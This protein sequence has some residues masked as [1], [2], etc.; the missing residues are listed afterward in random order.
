MSKRLI[1]IDDEGDG[2]QDE[3]LIA[4]FFDLFGSVTPDLPLVSQ[5]LGLYPIYQQLKLA[6]MANLAQDLFIGRRSGVGTGIPQT[7]SAAQAKTILA[8]SHVDLSDYEIG[9]F[10]PTFTAATPGTMSRTYTVQDG[11]Y[12][13][14]G[15]RCLCTLRVAVSNWTKGT[16]TGAFTI[17]G[18]PFTQNSTT[19]QGAA[20]GAVSADGWTKAG[21]TDLAV[22]VKGGAADMAIMVSGSGVALVDL[23]IDD[24]PDIGG[25][26]ASDWRCT[27][28][29]KI[30]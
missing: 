4:E 2:I 1:I 5:G 10:T 8:L 28:S 6:G 11:H 27:F 16:A 12:V 3:L 19:P 20:Q 21:Y 18:L 17:G 13:R 14:L 22:R 9:T 30:A 24:L 15:N 23:S 29:Y 7:I 25:A 26:D